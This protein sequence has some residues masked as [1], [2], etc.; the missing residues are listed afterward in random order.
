[1][2]IYHIYAET[3]EKWLDEHKLVEY[4]S[5]IPPEDD[6]L[7]CQEQGADIFAKGEIHLSTTE[8]RIF[9]LNIIYAESYRSGHN[10]LDSKFCSHFGT[11]HLKSLDL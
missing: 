6:K 10:E 1:M 5:H 8:I 11:S 4:T 3:C 7:A 2:I 9:K